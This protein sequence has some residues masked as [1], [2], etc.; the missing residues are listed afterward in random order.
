MTGTFDRR[1]R[2]TGKLPEGPF[3]T[4]SVQPLS[5]YLLA[6]FPQIPLPATG[7]PCSVPSL[8]MYVIEGTERVAQAPDVKRGAV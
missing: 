5:N 4:H 3:R 7:E 2:P 6:P 1:P 8:N